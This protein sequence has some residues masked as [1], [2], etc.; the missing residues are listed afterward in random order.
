M[1]MKKII[2]LVLTIAMLCG[3]V[4]ALAFS[5]VP[6]NSQYK[7]AIDLMAE[8]GIIKGHGDDTFGYDEICTRAQFITFLYR[9]A[10]EPDAGKAAEFTDVVNGEYYENAI[11]W[12]YNNGIIKP[13]EDGSIGVDV[14]VDRNHAATFLFEWAKVTGYGNVKAY[15]KLADYAD[16]TDI[17]QY[18]LAAYCWAVADGVI[19]PDA[20]NKILPNEEVTRSWTAN[21]IAKLITAHYHNWSEYKDNGDGTCQRVCALDEAHIE[22]AEHKFNFGELTKKVTETED[23]EITYTCVNCKFQKVEAVKAGTEVVTRAD[24]EEAAVATAWAYY[25]KGP[26]IQYDSTI[27]SGRLTSYFGGSARLTARTAPEYSTKHFNFYSVCSDYAH[28]VYNEG[29][30]IWAMGNVSQPFGIST[31]DIFRFSNNQQDYL[32]AEAAIFEPQTENDVDASVMNWINFEQYRERMN[33][34]KNKQMITTNVYNVGKFTEF[35]KEL[36][37]KND[38]LDGQIHYSYYD[39]EGNKL[40]PIE[41]K[42]EYVDPFFQEPDKNMRP[43][44]II[45]YQYSKNGGHTT[46]YVGNNLTL[47]CNGSKL[48]RDT[49][50]DK[51]EADGAIFAHFD[52][53]LTKWKNENLNAIVVTRPN[54][55]ILSEGFDDDLG[56]DI[57]NNAI[58]E[59]TKSRLKYP[60][61]N[62]DRTVD[63]THFGTAVKGGNLTYT[64]E[65]SNHTNDEAYLQWGKAYNKGEE[66][67]KGIKVTEAIPTGTELVEDS[68]VGGG[69]FADGVVTWDLA[70]IAPGEKVTLSYTV[71]VTAEIGDTIVSDGGMV[72]KIPSNSITNKVGGEKLSEAEAEALAKIADGGDEGLKQFGKDTDFAEGIYKTM[73]IELDLPSAYDITNELFKV[74]AHIPGSDAEVGGLTGV[75]NNPVNLC[76]RQKVVKDEYKPIQAMLV[77][78]YW[79]GDGYYDG[80][81]TKWQFA[82]KMIKDFRTDYLEKGDILVY[83]GNDVADRDKLTFQLRPVKTGVMVYDGRKLLCTLTHNGETTYKVYDETEIDTQLLQAL[84][85]EYDVFFNLRP[86][87]L[88][89]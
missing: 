68:I 62:I 73:G 57:S 61:M 13:F 3:T 51:V 83:I 64:I 33:A 60:M 69:T 43:G 59:D 89:E 77:D 20:E 87:Q 54:E 50:E 75:D 25:V 46:L 10:G 42:T 82:T 11:T 71:K 67:Y 8:K 56:N 7:E 65:V 44:D 47:H 48:N 63:I 32:T 1:K 88:V 21:A 85:Y 19:T 66:T 30:N 28:Q 27:M 39:K 4:Q 35:N 12:A 16:A 72:D 84:D 2:A 79:G 5:D 37:F 53:T 23:G 6:E 80:D 34:S 45:V 38:S 18:A 17:A 26:Y 78:R 31:F 41:V 76:V 70:D 58:P 49:A 9:A 52:Y 36:E 86:S 40:D 22:K 15:C 74:Q 14:T 81:E 29:L 24:L 55:F